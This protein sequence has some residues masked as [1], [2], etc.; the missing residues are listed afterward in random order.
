M[1]F[2]ARRETEEDDDEEQGSKRGEKLSKKVLARVNSACF[3]GVQLSEWEN[4]ICWDENIAHSAQ[5]ASDRDSD[6]E[7]KL[8]IFFNGMTMRQC[9]SGTR[10]AKTLLFVWVF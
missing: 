5:F 10:K 9:L 2:R 4:N 6:N 3:H 1:A 7:G 8:Q